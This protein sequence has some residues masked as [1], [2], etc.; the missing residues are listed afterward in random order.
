MGV[1][2]ENQRIARFE[3]GRDLVVPRHQPE[4]SPYGRRQQRQMGHEDDVTRVGMGGECL[5][6]ERLDRLGG[7]E[8]VDRDVEVAPMRE[9]ITAVLGERL[10]QRV[11]QYRQ[12]HRVGRGV[13]LAVPDG[14]DVV[15][16]LDDQK[17]QIFGKTLF[18]RRVGLADHRPLKFS[19]VAI[20]LRKITE[21]DREGDL[22]H[23]GAFAGRGEERRGSRLPHLEVA[24]AFVPSAVG[25]G[26]GAMKLRRIEVGVAHHEH[27]V[28]ARLLLPRRPSGR[29]AEKDR[30]NAQ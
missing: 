18:D 7:D 4:R 13:V 24:G 30:H 29:E 23:R 17:R 11:G 20:A 2:G 8:S 25:R 27:L 14:A 12:Q 6:D 28:I 26:R 15:I 1:S 22:F 3:H 19:V 21:L 9:R 10:P 5:F 16:A